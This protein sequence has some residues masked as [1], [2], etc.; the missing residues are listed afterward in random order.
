MDNPSPRSLCPNMASLSITEEARRRKSCLD[1]WNSDL[2]TLVSASNA[3]MT[4]TAQLVKA[5][6]LNDT[7]PL[8]A[9]GV[10]DDGTV[11]SVTDVFNKIGD[12]LFEIGLVE[13]QARLSKSSLVRRRNRMAD[14][15]SVSRLPGV[16]RTRLD[17]WTF[18]LTDPHPQ[19]RSSLSSSST[20]PKPKT[21]PLLHGSLA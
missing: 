11:A 21:L 20:S 7:A 3:Y 14:V 10:V 15:T 17:A 13:E 9:M 16:Y 19:M 4:T 5:C 8:Q 18:Q 12:R 2:D 1:Q 6:P